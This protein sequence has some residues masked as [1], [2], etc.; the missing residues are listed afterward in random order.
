MERRK[1]WEELVREEGGQEFSL[2]H[3]DYET[4]TKYSNENIQ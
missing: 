1:P 2:A 3:V 4:S